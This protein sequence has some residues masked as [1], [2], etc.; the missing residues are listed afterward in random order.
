MQA[1]S[2]AGSSCS[3]TWA[4]TTVG[5]VCSASEVELSPLTPFL[6]SGGAAEA[7]RRAA[8]AAVQPAAS[9]EEKSRSWASQGAAAAAA[10]APAAPGDSTGARADLWAAVP[11]SPPA[12][13]PLFLRPGIPPPIWECAKAGGGRGGGREGTLAAVAAA[14]ARNRELFSRRCLLPPAPRGK[15]G[16]EKSQMDRAFEEVINRGSAFC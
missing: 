5:Q 4:V 10:A 13:V 3:L 15:A 14:A 9:Q 8:V 12:A 7:G 6:G 2:Q 11:N 16:R 1:G